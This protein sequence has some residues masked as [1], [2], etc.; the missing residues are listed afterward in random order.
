MYQ[1]AENGPYAIEGALL[2]VDYWKPD[3]VMENLVMDKMAIWGKLHGL[4]MECFTE[5]AEFRLERAI[6]DI[7]KVDIDTLMP[8]N[9]WF[10]RI[11]M[12]IPIDGPLT[13]GFFPEV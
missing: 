10:L 8:H 3:L 4:P 12:R 9:I 7:D 1:I 2:V 6:G 11:S 13:S 5:E